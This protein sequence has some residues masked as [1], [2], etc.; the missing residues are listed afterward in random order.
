VSRSWSPTLVTGLAS[1]ESDRC[2]LAQ[3]VSK[4]SQIV[5]LTSH[6][7]DK[8]VGG[9]TYLKTPGFTLSRYTVRNGGAPATLDVRI[10]FSAEGP[11]YP[12]DVK[13]GGWRGA[14]ITVWVAL[15]SSP[16]VREIVGNGFT[17]KTVFSDRLEGTLSLLTRADALKDIVLFTIQPKCKFLLYGTECGVDE[18]AEH[19][20]IGLD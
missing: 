8:V 18:V 2:F 11:I 15:A 6:D 13:R 17:G 5:R 3:L 7:V 20:C 10:P 4:T 1:T 12:N 14:A 16:S 9:N 19:W